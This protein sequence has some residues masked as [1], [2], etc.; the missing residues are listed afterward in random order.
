LHPV[1]RL[2]SKTPLALLILAALVLITAPARGDQ[3]RAR[4]KVEK[5]GITFTPEVFLQKVA[6]GD[7]HTRRAAG[8]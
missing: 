3:A 1:R 5:A 6:E 7:V 8:S 2:R 4:E